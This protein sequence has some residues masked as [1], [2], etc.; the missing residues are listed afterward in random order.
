MPL[1]S[2]LAQFGQP[3]AKHAVDWPSSEGDR[4]NPE[5]HASTH[6][7]SDVAPSKVVWLGSAPLVH[8]TAPVDPAVGSGACPPAGQGLHVSSSTRN[9]P[10]T[11]F[12]QPALKEPGLPAPNMLNLCVVGLISQQRSWAKD[13]AA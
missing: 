1:A 10:A 3:P 4:T 7:S 11:H 9:S 6:S 12:R 8:A 2:A 13:V 5:S